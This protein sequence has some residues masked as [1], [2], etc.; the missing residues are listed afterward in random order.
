MSMQ[1][2]CSISTIH[3]HRTVDYA[4]LHAEAGN[5]YQPNAGARKRGPVGS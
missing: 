2:T 4:Q 3:E 1:W 5:R